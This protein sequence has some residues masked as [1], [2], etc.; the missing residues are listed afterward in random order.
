MSSRSTKGWPLGPLRPLIAAGQSWA[1]RAIMCSGPMP[2]DD[3]AWTGVQALPFISKRL[4]GPRAREPHP[5]P[6]SGG[7]S[8]GF[9]RMMGPAA[10]GPG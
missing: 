9:A 2:K 10:R 5:A 3:G 4:S 8:R 1:R 6:Y 7:L